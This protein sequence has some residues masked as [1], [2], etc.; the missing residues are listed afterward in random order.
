M[1]VIVEI[2]A[3]IITVILAIFW[4][5]NP[6]GNYEPWTVI[7]GVITVGSDIIRRLTKQKNEKSKPSTAEE[8]VSWIQNEGLEKPLSQVLPRVL[9]LAKLIND[10]KLEHWVRMEINGY[11]KKVGMTEQDVV[12]EYRE[13]SGK[14][15]DQYNRM[16][17]ISNPNLAFV[18]TYRF[19]LGVRQLEELS[20]KSEMQNIRDETFIDLLKENLKVDVIRFCFS[21]VEVAGV[22]DRIRNELMEKLDATEILR[23]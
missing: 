15:M 14:Y 12:P 13:I 21:P 23:K 20:S 19:R 11:D 5:R 2:I 18:N 22:L 10:N 3:L 1:I 17:K 8:L 4:I 16:L 6:R 9:K 7:C